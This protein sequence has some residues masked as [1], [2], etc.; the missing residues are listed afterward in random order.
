VENDMFMGL[1]N[2]RRRVDDG[3]GVIIR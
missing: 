1:T 3:M 2:K